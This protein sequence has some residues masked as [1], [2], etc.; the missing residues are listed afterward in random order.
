MHDADAAFAGAAR[1]GQKAGDFLVRFV[2]VEAMQIGMVADR[3]ATASQ[4]AQDA[5]RQSATQKGVGIADGQQVVDFKRAV[6][7]FFDGGGFV[8]FALTR[9]RAGFGW[10]EGDPLRRSQRDGSVNGRVKGGEFFRGRLLPL[11]HG[12]GEFFSLAPGTGFR[13]KAISQPSRLSR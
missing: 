8:E 11:A 7:G 4:V 12:R 9:V 3:P 6:Q 5:A 10:L 13:R 2:A 1:F